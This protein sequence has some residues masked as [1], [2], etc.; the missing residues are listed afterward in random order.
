MGSM[1]S[2]PS[3]AAAL[4]AAYYRPAVQ[5]LLRWWS[6]FG[7]LVLPTECAGCSAPDES[8]CAACRA[9][10][11]RATARPYR[12]EAGAALLPFL[13]DRPDAPVLPVVAA[14]R[15]RHE[16]A[17]AILAFKNH[18]RTDLAPDLAVILARAVQEA[19]RQLAAGPGPWLLVPVPS[20]PGSRRRR[21]YAPLE[22]LL[23]RLER[24]R[25][26]PPEAV[27]LRAAAVR[28]SAGARL[29][30]L[31]PGPSQKA[32]GRSARRR[33]AA[34]SMRLRPGFRRSVAGCRCLL[35]DDVLTTG[36]TLAELART[37]R[38]AGGQVAGAVVLA[39][40]SAP[41]GDPPAAD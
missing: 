4:D 15:Y 22:L 17:R 25:L 36:A 19:A 3:L 7:R 35:L 11:S 37:V 33:N 28:A 18:G 20:R 24:R 23:R 30:R 40:T 10:I 39:A 16:F 6:D 27:P 32:L 26:L 9:G 38:E 34:G 5:L 29:R 12:A 2:S 1:F 21:G 8:L 41:S 14:G 31:L 13:G